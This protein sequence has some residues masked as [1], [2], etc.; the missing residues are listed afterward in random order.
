MRERDINRSFQNP[1]ESQ[2]FH[3][4]SLEAVD[5]YGYISPVQRFVRRYEARLL[6]DAEK[7]RK[8]QERQV[9]QR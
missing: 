1:T 7:R 4:I 3:R 9:Q 5:E 2:A 8:R 6:R